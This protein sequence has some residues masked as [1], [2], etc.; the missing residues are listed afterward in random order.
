VALN[1]ISRGFGPLAVQFGSDQTVPS[2]GKNGNSTLKKPQDYVEFS[3]KSL[4][5]LRIRKLVDSLP[6]FRIE[7]VN[8]LSQ[9]IDQG[10]YDVPGIQIAEAIIKKN[11]VDF[12]E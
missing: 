9:A 12:E 4:E 6:D 10:T 3:D 11:L 2:N 7:R 5:F 8:Q 1:G